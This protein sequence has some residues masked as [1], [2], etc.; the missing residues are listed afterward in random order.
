MPNDGE[1]A[2]Q[3]LARYEKHATKT[4]GATRAGM[5]LG[6]AVQLLPTPTTQD[7][8]NCAGPSQLE[9]NSLPLNTVVALLP[10]PTAWLGRRESHSTGDPE[11]WT[12]PERSNELSDCVAWISALTPKQS[13]DG[14]ISWVEPPLHL[15]TTDD[16]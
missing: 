9:R 10:T 7:A 13:P 8:A 15:S 6:I 4:E 11:R 12:N 3:W 1:P 14:L 5:P 2:E 16:D